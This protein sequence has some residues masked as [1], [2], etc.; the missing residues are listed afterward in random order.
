MFFQNP[1]RSHSNSFC[2]QKFFHSGPQPRPGGYAHG[3]SD[4]IEG[5]THS[6]C[7]LEFELHRPLY[8]WSAPSA[9]GDGIQEGWGANT[10][11]GKAAIAIISHNG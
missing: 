1:F 8:E 6:V 9:S 4:A 11:G 5:I 2:V 3:Q 10:G 7:T